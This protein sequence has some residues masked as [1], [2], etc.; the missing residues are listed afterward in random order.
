MNIPKY[1]TP[2]WKAYQYKCQLEARRGK[3]YRY[4]DGTKIDLLLDRGYI[5]YSEKIHF[6]ST[7]LGVI[8][9]LRESGNFAQMYLIANSVRGCSDVVILYKPKARSI[10]KND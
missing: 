7:G 10:T 2:Q 6:P 4:D 5:E 8:K 3:N 1:G 9:K